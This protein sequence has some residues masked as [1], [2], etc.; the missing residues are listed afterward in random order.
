M[1]LCGEGIWRIFEERLP[2]GIYL[3]HSFLSPAKLECSF[4][5]D[6]KSKGTSVFPT[7]SVD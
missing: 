6:K 7:V 4:P 2:I 5:S 1:M 3:C